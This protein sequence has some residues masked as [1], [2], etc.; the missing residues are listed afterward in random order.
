MTKAL[1][2]RTELQSLFNTNWSLIDNRDAI[3]KE[4]K[5]KSFQQAWGWMTEIA[6]CAE[7]LDHHPEWSNTYNRVQVVLTT[8]SCDGLSDLDIKLA[9]LMDE[10]AN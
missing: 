4:F 10:A 2:D 8:H 7:K 3:S 6:L 5:F 9:K 1:S